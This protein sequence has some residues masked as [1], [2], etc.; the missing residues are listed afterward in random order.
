[1]KSSESFTICC[2][3]LRLCGRTRVTVGRGCLGVWFEGFKFTAMSRKFAALLTVNAGEVWLAAPLTGPRDFRAP[4]TIQPAQLRR[5]AI[6]FVRLSVDIQIAYLLYPLLPLR[7]A[8]CC[9]GTV[10][11]VCSTPREAHPR[12]LARSEACATLF[13]LIHFQISDL[14]VLG[15]S[16][17]LSKSNDANSHARRAIASNAITASRSTTCPTSRCVS[18]SSS[19]SPKRRTISMAPIA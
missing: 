17:E 10:F 18:S 19:P 11:C 13:S 8:A 14:P 9:R 6:S 15:P 16:P 4:T 7:R 3:G 5:N 1:M 2:C 12:P